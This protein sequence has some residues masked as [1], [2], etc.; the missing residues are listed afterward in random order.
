LNLIAG[1]ASTISVDQHESQHEQRDDRADP[2][3]PADQVTVAQPGADRA[4][5]RRGRDARPSLRPGSRCRG[6]H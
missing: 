2:A 5:G 4:P 6:R 3:Q 1:I